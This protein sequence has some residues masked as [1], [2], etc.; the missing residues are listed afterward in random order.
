[1]P[2]WLR[3][4]SPEIYPLN[5]TPDPGVLTNFYL[6]LRSGQKRSLIS[7]AIPFRLFPSIFICL[8]MLSQFCCGGDL[9]AQSGSHFIEELSG[10]RPLAGRE[11]FTVELPKSDQDREIEIVLK[12]DQSEIVLASYSVNG[13]AAKLI[14]GEDELWGPD[15]G[16]IPEGEVVTRIQ[17]VS[18]EVINL[19]TVRSWKQTPWYPKG[20][21]RGEILDRISRK[22]RD[23]KPVDAFRELKEIDRGGGGAQQEAEWF[24]LNAS[25]LDVFSRI[26]R[27]NGP[28]AQRNL[29][30]ALALAPNDSAVQAHSFIDRAR[31]FREE[32]LSQLDAGVRRNGFIRSLEDARSALEIAT[33]RG[34]RVLASA[35]LVEI[36][37][38]SA[39]RGWITETRSAV[40]SA[41]E[42]NGDLDTLWETE[43]ALAK[44]HYS[45][46][47]ISEAI[48]RSRF[49]VEAVEQIRLRHGDDDS[50]LFHRRE[51]AFL[52]TELLA[53]SGNP[54]ESLQASELLRIRRPGDSVP[55]VDWIQSLAREAEGEFRIQVLVST[56]DRLLNWWTENGKWNLKIADFELGELEEHIDRLH[57]SRGRDRESA[58]W[59]SGLVFDGNVPKLKRL[60]LLPLDHLRRVPWAGL[61]VAGRSLLDR[62][63]CS[64]LPDLVAASRELSALP[65]DQ[66]LS[67]VDP[68]VPGM[69]RLPGAR[70]EGVLV[71]K[72]L[73]ASTVLSGSAATISGLTSHLAGR[74][75]LHLG[76]HG[77]FDPRNPRASQLRLSPDA[78]S[79]DGR[80]RAEKLEKWD[81]SSCRLVLLTGCET[82]MAGGPGADDLAGFP[83][84]VLRAGCQGI[85]GSLWPVEDEVTRQ[86]TDHLIDSAA[87]RIS[88]A[89][90]LRDAC[91]SIRAKSSVNHHVSAWSGWVLVENGR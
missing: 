90:A 53:L 38:T 51:P 56:G 34:D 84:A 50:V 86:L 31:R 21:S 20:N 8:C 91:R 13:Q 77:D 71:A 74:K 78:G 9:W 3:L 27:L 15:P 72:K 4:R 73:G 30:R 67:L 24:R 66:W 59:I 32:G 36:A 65:A 41:R 85:L 76:C 68:D 40:E 75:F 12:T 25:I 18:G 10:D 52:L 60:L 58:A 64:L 55:G 49:A 69:N 29:D 42:L 22:L 57:S 88:P 82:A 81:L 35:A 11:L 48:E 7:P 28:Q 47:E 26:D 17:K 1:M 87:A 16:R 54:V 23:G 33:S 79:P 61:P 45:R 80:L 70:A 63:A 14:I 62:T 39:A 89:E 44:A 6:S 83:R 43:L 5:T 46:G 2:P 37:L 19:P